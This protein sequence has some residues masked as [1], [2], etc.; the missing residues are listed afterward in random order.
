MHTI[1]SNFTASL[2]ELKRSP[3]KILADAHGEPVAILNHN[4][5]EAY[6]IPANA[7]EAIMDVMEDIELAGIVRKR[8]GEKS[9]KVNIDEI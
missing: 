5:P 3:M 8:Q 9:I 7:Y 4:T 2:S 1:L 6:L